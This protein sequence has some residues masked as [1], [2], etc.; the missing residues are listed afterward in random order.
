MQVSL[1][2]FVSEALDEQFSINATLP[3]TLTAL[4]F[5]PGFLTAEYLRGRIASYIAPFRLYLV[6][7]VSFFLLL[8][9]RGLETTPLQEGT[10][11]PEAAVAERTVPDTTLPRFGI[12]MDTT[13]TYVNTGIA[14]LDSVLLE[15]LA[16]MREMDPEDAIRTILRRVLEDVPTIMFFL[17]P[18]FA[19]LLKLLYIRRKR[20]YVEH[21]TLRSTITRSHS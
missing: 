3:R 9:V 13:G 7:S 15:R 11:P 17:L 21:F 18:V 19:L 16:T 10:D 8:S 2:R 14:A 1:G 6:A 4:L 20:Y 12:F 5:R